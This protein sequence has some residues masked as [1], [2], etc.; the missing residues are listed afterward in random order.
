VSLQDLV[1]LARARRVVR[2]LL[3]GPNTPHDAF[4]RYVSRNLRAQPRLMPWFDSFPGVPTTREVE[5]MALDAWLGVDET[6]QRVRARLGLRYFPE[7][8]AEERA[9]VDRGEA[10]MVCGR[11]TRSF[12]PITAEL[13]EGEPCEECGA[14][15]WV[16]DKLRFGVTTTARCEDCAGMGFYP[17]RPPGYPEGA[18]VIAFAPGHLDRRWWA[19][20]RSTVTPGWRNGYALS[21]ATLA[22]VFARAR[23]IG[24]VVL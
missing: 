12:R 18:D 4:F 21:G 13:R 7:C 9:Q 17:E 23:E 1:D 3:W 2:R 19:E 5:I 10:F 15:G 11:F 8:N 20:F 14:K 22:D 24:V 6:F 16:E